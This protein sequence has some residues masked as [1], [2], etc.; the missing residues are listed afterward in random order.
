[1][2]AAEIQILLTLLDRAASWGTV[3][4]QARA[5]GRP[6]SEAEITAFFAADDAADKRLQDA[7]AKAKAEGR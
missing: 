1:M 3:V 4:A 2:G 7:I 6:V 5:E